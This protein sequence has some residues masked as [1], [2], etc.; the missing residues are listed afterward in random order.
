[1]NEPAKKPR[2]PP[3]QF[4]LLGLMVVMFVCAAAAAPG[5]YMLHSR[6]GMPQA[7]LVGM[8]M[9]LA[10]PLLLMTVL[11]VLLSLLGR[12]DSD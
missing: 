1:M 11:S 2:R 3:F 7:R 6:E 10:G 12:G 8:L 5:Y 9:M 4:S